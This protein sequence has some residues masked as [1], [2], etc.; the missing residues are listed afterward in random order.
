V[1]R[2]TLL[3]VNKLQQNIHEQH[4]GTKSTTVDAADSFILSKLSEPII[5]QKHSQTSAK[6]V[7]PAK[8]LQLPP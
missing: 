5:N 3:K 1:P 4:I 8:F 2:V 6:A 7:D